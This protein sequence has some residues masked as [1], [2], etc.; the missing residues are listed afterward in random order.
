MMPAN[1]IVAQTCLGVLHLDE[2]VA[3][4]DLEVFPLA[5]YA[6]QQWVAHARIKDV[7]PK[8]KIKCGISS[9]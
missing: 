7:S 2:N 1:T 3:E 8:S 9:T 4:E 6:A 5:E